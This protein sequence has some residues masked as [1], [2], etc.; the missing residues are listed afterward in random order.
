MSTDYS[1]T[2]L[3]SKLKEI[4]NKP[5]ECSRATN[6]GGAGNLLEDLLGIEENNLRV[7]DYGTIEIKTQRQESSSLL[8]LFHN[9]PL[10]P[11]SVPKMLLSLG[12][13]HAEAGG[14]HDENEMSFRSTTY[15]HRYSDRGFKINV[16][17]DQL[18]FDFNPNEVAISK[19][20]KTGVYPTYGD[21]LDSVQNREPHYSSIMPIYYELKELA[22]TFKSKID[23]TLLA[24]VK[25]SSIKGIKHH[26]YTEFF[27]MSELKFEKV[28]DAMRKGDIALDFDARTR[29][30]HGTK[31]R[32]SKECLPNLFN[33][34]EHINI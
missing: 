14:R 23:H 26:T 24:L 21:W 15:G 31:F 8:T 1:L 4:C 12:W 25:T 6:D 7:P 28:I 30:N 32:L 3:V 33:N 11:A 27:I 34:Y 20:D 29:K 17:E 18:I 2:R 9:E 22:N 13:R 19:P 5:Y 16:T 10:P